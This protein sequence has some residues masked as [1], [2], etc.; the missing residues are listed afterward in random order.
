MTDKPINPFWAEKAEMF[1][2]KNPEVLERLRRMALKTKAVGRN[3]YGM[4]VLYNAL[5]WQRDLETRD[6]TP[7]KLND[8]Y[9]AWYARKLM[10]IEP[11]LEGFF[12]LRENHHVG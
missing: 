1:H 8:A 12:E 9:H 3:R 5:R 11:E 10:E 7:Y 4:K 2:E 6:N